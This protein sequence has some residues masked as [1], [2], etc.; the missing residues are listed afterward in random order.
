MC[1]VFYM[2]LIVDL[3]VGMRRNIGAHVWR[4][5]WLRYSWRRNSTGQSIFSQKSFGVFEP[6]L[7]ERFE[8]AR[9]SWKRHRRY[10][11]LCS[12]E[13]IGCRSF[14]GRR[15]RRLYPWQGRYRTIES[16]VVCNYNSWR[17]FWGRER[18][19]ER[20]KPCSWRGSPKTGIMS[21]TY[22]TITIILTIINR[23]IREPRW[24]WSR[25]GWWRLEKKGLA[26]C[27][28]NI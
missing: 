5:S 28:R 6:K 10:R 27:Q 16:W 23:R 26:T 9:K 7:E 2:I 13:G 22:N 3:T 24:M 17:L 21:T 8:I 25:S 19:K 20:G 15:S 1:H 4:S 12:F 14:D 11:R 18:E